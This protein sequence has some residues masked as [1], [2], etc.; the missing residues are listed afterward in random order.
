MQVTAPQMEKLLLGH[1]VFKQ[2]AFSML[3]TRLKNEYAAAPTK[4]LLEHC[5][6][7]INTFLTKYHTIMAA[8]FAVIAAV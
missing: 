7:E 6:K 3:L 5:A 1:Y 2:F 4:P 8:D